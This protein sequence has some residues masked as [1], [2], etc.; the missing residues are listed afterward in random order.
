MLAGLAWIVALGS[1]HLPAYGG[2]SQAGNT[3]L[4]QKP[5]TWHREECC[6]GKMICCAVATTT[7]Q[8]ECVGILACCALHVISTSHS[9]GL[10]H[11]KVHDTS[12]E[13]GSE[14]DLVAAMFGSA[15][16]TVLRVPDHST[17]VTF[18]T[19][20]K[21]GESRKQGASWW[22]E[23][24]ASLN[25]LHGHD[26]YCCKQVI[27]SCTFTAVAISAVCLRNFKVMTTLK[28]Y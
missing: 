12:C 7:R 8:A 16:N 19:R 28:I 5:W 9:E 14:C 21:L 4:K 27:P 20:S 11:V 13:T 18:A 15:C 10:T 23:L 25:A 26:L 2:N 1:N 24:R 22:Q 17:S 3:L 6:A